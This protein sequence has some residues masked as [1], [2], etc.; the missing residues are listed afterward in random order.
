MI[1]LQMNVFPKK[2]LIVPSAGA[3]RSEGKSHV[4]EKSDTLVGASRCSIQS[5]ESERK[6][7]AG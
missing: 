7:L 4:V 2:N 6:I 1:M 3:V 5:W